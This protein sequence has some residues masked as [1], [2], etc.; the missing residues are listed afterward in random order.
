MNYRNYSEY[1]QKWGEFIH[2][3]SIL[4]LLFNLGPD[5][6]EYIDKN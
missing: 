4:D 2:N 3:V 1:P 6:L 5:C